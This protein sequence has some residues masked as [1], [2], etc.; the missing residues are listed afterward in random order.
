MEKPDRQEVQEKRSRNFKLALIFGVI[1][2]GWYVL[3]M[4]VIWKQ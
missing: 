2:A 4:L 3:A 1:A